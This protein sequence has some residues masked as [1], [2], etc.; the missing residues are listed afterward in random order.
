M[1]P[2]W[3]CG[4]L[5]ARVNVQVTSTSPGPDSLLEASRDPLRKRLQQPSTKVHLVSQLFKKSS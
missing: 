1:A 5:T 4:G 3:P 2:T